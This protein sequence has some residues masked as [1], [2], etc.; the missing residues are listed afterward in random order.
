MPA[1]I[2]TAATCRCRRPL[3]AGRLRVV[4]C[5]LCNVMTPALM[6]Q[7]PLAQQTV[8]QHC[9][10]PGP[11]LAITDVVESTRTH[12]AQQPQWLPCVVRETHAYKHRD[13]NRHPALPLEGPSMH[14]TEATTAQPSLGT[15]VVDAFCSK[16]L[17]APTAVVSNTRSDCCKFSKAAR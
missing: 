4:A 7:S 13:P 2:A 5:A 10:S 1:A 12:T 6:Q 17:N 3:Q 14:T 11:P 15:R 8:S 16:R 9:C